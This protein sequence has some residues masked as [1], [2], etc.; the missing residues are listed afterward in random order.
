MR[1]GTVIRLKGYKIVEFFSSNYILVILTLLFFLGLL[2]GTLSGNRFEFLQTLSNRYL[3]SFAAKRSQA[4]FLSLTTHSFLT[5][6]LL[7][8][9][10]FALGTSM[11]GIILTP[12]ALMLRGIFYGSVSALLYSQYAVKGIA[13]N[14]VIVLPA[15]LFS[16]IALLLAARESIQFSLMIA[17]Y[18]LPSASS[19]N[20]SADFGNYCGRYLVLTLII[21][22]S[23]VVDG[24]VSCT[25]AGNF[26]L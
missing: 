2:F 23:A 20:L 15:A 21:L 7:L 5:S 26:G 4:S 3:E 12:L 10:C 24:L 1:K 18:S 11:F 8:F 25:F 17:K 6:M 14:A 13:F 16:I 22:L 9:L 19:G